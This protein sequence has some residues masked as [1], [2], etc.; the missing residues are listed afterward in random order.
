MK[1]KACFSSLSS[2]ATVVRSASAAPRTMRL[3]YYHRGMPRGALLPDRVVPNRW[4]G[5]PS[6]SGVD[7][8]NLGKYFFGVVDRKT[9]RILYSRG[10]ASI[11]GEW[12][13][14]GVKPK[15]IHR[16]FHESLR[17]P[18]PSGRCRSS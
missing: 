12:E 18:A 16:T 15:E 13:S 11:Y 3:D 7:D 1:R 2:L 5:W 9:N 8:A 4:N 17:F 14:T 6:G 10:F